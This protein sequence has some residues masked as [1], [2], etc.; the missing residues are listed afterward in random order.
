MLAVYWKPAVPVNCADGVKITVSSVGSFGVPFRF[1][2]TLPFT[3]FDTE[4]TASDPAGPPPASLASSV[5]TGMTSCCPREVVTASSSAA[6]PPAT[7]AAVIE[8]S[9]KMAWNA[10]LSA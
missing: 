9:L 5:P 2:A 10:S 1:R 7:E 4:T 3:A 8:T 6:T